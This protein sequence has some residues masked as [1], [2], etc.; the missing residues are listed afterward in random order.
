MSDEYNAIDIVRAAIEERDEAAQRCDDLAN[1]MIYKGNSV[2][3]IYSKSRKYGDALI[4]AL[5][6]LSEAG[7]VCDEKTSVT[8]GIRLL[9]AKLKEK[10]DE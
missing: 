1:T 2:A 9:A 8:D 7:I 6:A 4:D 5:G 3:Y 10:N